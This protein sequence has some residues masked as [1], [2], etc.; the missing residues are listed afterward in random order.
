[1]EQSDVTDYCACCWKNSHLLRQQRLQVRIVIAPHDADIANVALKFT[2]K[3]RD[4]VPLAHFRCDD[5]ELY[6]SQDQERVGLMF[7]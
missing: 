2:E 3:V 1:V 5:R 4:I 7:G 6:I